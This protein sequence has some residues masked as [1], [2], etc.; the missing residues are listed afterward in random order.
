MRGPDGKW[1]LL[2]DELGAPVDDTGTALWVAQR[3][4]RP[5]HYTA[6]WQPPRGLNGTFRFAVGREHNVVYSE[7][8]SL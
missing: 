3:R 4:S 6:V 1:S 2:K 5:N 7:G 8:F